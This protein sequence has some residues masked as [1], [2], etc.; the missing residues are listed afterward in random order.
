MTRVMDSEPYRP[1]KP[2]F[3]RDFFAGEPR[4][5]Q[6]EYVPLRLLEIREHHVGGPRQLAATG[7]ELGERPALVGSVHQQDME[8]LGARRAHDVEQILQVG[9]VLAER[10]GAK[11][12]REIESGLVEPVH[13]TPSRRR[14]RA[15]ARRNGAAA[16]PAAPTG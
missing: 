8:R 4:P 3:D 13:L 14:P 6:L 15:P 7:L 2:S 5:A 12:A 1:R 10:I 11:L 9:A 16:R